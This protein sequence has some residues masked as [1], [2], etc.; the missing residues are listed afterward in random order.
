ME[1]F[2]GTS[3]PWGIEQTDNRNWIGPIRVNGHKVESIVCD[4]DREGI[5]DKYLKINDSNA[6]LIAAAPE[7]LEALQKLCFLNS[8]EL[9]GVS[10]GMPSPEDWRKAFEKSESVINK[11]LGK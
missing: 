1:E 2:K 6:K 7:L 4:T 3:G 8:C 10:S 5:K 11:A 9:E